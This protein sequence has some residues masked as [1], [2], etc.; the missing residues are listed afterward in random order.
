MTTATARIGIS[1]SQAIANSR[2][3]SRY[4]QRTDQERRVNERTV[5]DQRQAN[6]RSKRERNEQTPPRQLEALLLW[7]QR[8]IQLD[9]PDALHT[10]SIWFD[11][12]TNTERTTGLTPVGGSLIG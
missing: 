8:E 12:V 2:A 3:E 11:T 10:S 9:L 6:W 4:R 1:E 5:D 7:F